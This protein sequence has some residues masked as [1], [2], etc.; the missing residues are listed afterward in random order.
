MSNLIVLLP[1]PFA[2]SS[3]RAG[4]ATHA[5]VARS[6]DGL[7]DQD[8]YWLKH[9]AGRILEQGYGRLEPHSLLDVQTWVAVLPAPTCSWHRVRIPPKTQARHLRAVLE[10]LLEEQ[11]LGDIA[12][13]HFALPP[14][15]HV[16][17][18][19]TVC[20]THLPW[21]Q[22]CQS[23][24]TGLMPAAQGRLVP[25]CVPLNASVA[26]AAHPALVQYAI[27]RKD[28]SLDQDILLLP[29][30]HAVRV[31]PILPALQTG[32]GADP[33]ALQHLLIWVDPR[34]AQLADTVFG[35]QH[36]A[37]DPEVVDASGGARRGV[38]W[39]LAD[40]PQRLLRIA[41]EPAQW[42]LAQ[43]DLAQ[44]Q[45]WAARWQRSAAVRAAQ[46]WAL[47]P[48]WRK[49][50]WALGMLAAVHIVGLNAYAWQ[51]ARQ[52]RAKEQQIRALLQQQF[53]EVTV[54]VDPLSQM[55]QA[56][57]LLQ[58]KHAD[59]TQAGG[60]SAMLA[61]LHSSLP[62]LGLLQVQFTTA[63]LQ[64]RT[65]SPALSELAV[66]ARLAQQGLSVQRLA[67]NG[68]GVH[69]WLLRY[70]PASTGAKALPASASE[71]AAPKN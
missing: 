48:Q 41:L 66:Q 33:A 35:P 69:T 49:A 16:V 51:Q 5:S 57:Q 55:Q 29:E 43:F 12:N 60:L 36:S 59:G 13:L 4:A 11:T 50:R 22:A 26:M 53:P 68:S 8:V 14:G 39:Q 1:P 58:D 71:A 65:A 6:S 31:W 34:C 23:V 56:V 17:G 61:G 21:L 67:D 3:G 54:V 7:S 46:A 45:G 28:D 37:S 30:Q 63:G 20:C 19:T 64:L 25:E 70:D 38:Q 18:E 40:A 62:Q 9:R 10:G 2:P 47:A 44:A 15:R 27:L 52:L 24:L 42:E 32:L